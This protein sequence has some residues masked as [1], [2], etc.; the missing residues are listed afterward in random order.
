M[1][2]VGTAVL[3]AGDVNPEVFAVG[4][5]ENQLIEVGVVLQIVEP[6]AGGLQVGMTL[7]VIPGGIAGEGQADVCGFAKGVLGGVGSTDTD[8]ELV[9]AV[10]AGD[11]DRATDEGTEGLKNFLVGISFRG[12]DGG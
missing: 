10:T 7:V 3:A 11:D 5:L 6:L 4:G 1:V 2:A 12:M 9:A 8:V